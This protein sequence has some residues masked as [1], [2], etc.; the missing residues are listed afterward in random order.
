MQLVIGSAVGLR[1]LPRFP[2][3]NEQAVGAYIGLCALALWGSRRYLWSISRKL[4]TLS[5]PLD[6]THEPI[7]Y[8]TATLI[9]IGVAILLL[10][11]C[12]KAGL[13]LWASAIFLASYF[14]I[15]IAI[16]RMRAELS[17]PV[18]DLWYAGASGPDTIMV[19][20]LCTK[21]LGS[22]NLTTIS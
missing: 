19:N 13:T 4:L 3:G 21:R 17:T 8:R 12:V 22:A 9:I 10:F 1:S 11:F 15:S 14:S 2:Y 5:S 18:H 16:T 7:K 6:D 20:I